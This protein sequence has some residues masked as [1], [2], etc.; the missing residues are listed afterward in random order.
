MSTTAVRQLLS[1]SGEAKVDNTTLMNALFDSLEN[2]SAPAHPAGSS[3][4]SPA[5]RSFQ[6]S[7]GKL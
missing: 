5:G 6:R 1:P 4:G 2:R 7:S 3:A